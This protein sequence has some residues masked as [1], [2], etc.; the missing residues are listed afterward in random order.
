L[1]AAYG[2]LG[3]KDKAFSLLEKCYTERNT[4]LIY[5]R[6]DPSLDPL[7]DDPRFGAMLRRIGLEP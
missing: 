2:W 4:R 6:S 3:D 1:A 5:I 7:R